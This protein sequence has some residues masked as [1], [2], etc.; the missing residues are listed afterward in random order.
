MWRTTCY[1]QSRGRGGRDFNPRPPCGGRPPRQTRTQLGK[2]FQS[3]SP[4]WRTTFFYGKASQDY[5]ISIHVPR[6]ED[7]GHFGESGYQAFLFQSTSP[8]WRTTRMK[9][10]G[11]SWEKNFNPRP[12]C[13]GRHRGRP[14]EGVF[15]GYFNPRPPCGGRL[16]PVTRRT[17]MKCISIHVPRVEDDCSAK[18]CS[19]AMTNFNP[20]P[21][22]GGRLGWKFE[23]EE[24][25]YFNPRP[26]C[27][28]RQF[29]ELKDA[30]FWSFQS[31]SPVWRTTPSLAKT[32]QN[33]GISIHV[34]RVEDDVVLY[35][36]SKKRFDFNP[37]PP[38]GGRLCGFCAIM[39]TDDFNP[40]PPC[41][42]RPDENLRH[43]LGEKFQSTSPVWRT[44]PR[45]TPDD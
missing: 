35:L 30:S 10:C 45:Q 44:T 26:P 41:G 36:C 24:K 21:P 6:V 20:R 12:P 31:T 17:R 19:R 27:G 23:K 5:Q 32:R 39:R 22:C 8:V 43:E 37:R 40:R 25:T 7:D 1:N 18:S 14:G 33:L 29:I 42:G 2:I 3:T 4:V 15:G 38:C 28:G 16:C 9:I 13:G 34:P 11:T